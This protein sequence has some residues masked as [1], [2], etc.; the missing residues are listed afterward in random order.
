MRDFALAITALGLTGAVIA[1][2]DVF[3]T[4]VALTQH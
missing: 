2:T 3:P 4:L 1:L